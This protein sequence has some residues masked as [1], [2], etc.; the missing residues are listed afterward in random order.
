MC[1]ECFL[2]ATRKILE[3]TETSRFSPLLSCNVR[4]KGVGWQKLSLGI[5]APLGSHLGPTILLA[6]VSHSPPSASP[7]YR[8]LICH[9]VTIKWTK[10][11]RRG[12]SASFL[13]WSEGHRHSLSPSATALLPLAI[14][15]IVHIF[16]CAFWWRRE[17]LFDYNQAES[18]SLS[19][20]S[21]LCYLPWPALSQLSIAGQTKGQ[22]GINIFC[23]VASIQV[24]GFV[25]IQGWWESPYL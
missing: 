4:H 3:K 23:R 13:Y 1:F 19:F 14:F 10:E 22:R 15:T 11:G 8:G 18:P 12:Q 17:R 7:V 21:V 16:V 20:F 25:S 5:Y 24:N 9:P 2:S 6:L